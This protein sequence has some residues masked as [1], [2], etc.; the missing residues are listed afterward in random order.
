MVFPL[1]MYTTSTLQLSRAM[2]F[3]FLRIVPQ[4]F[5]W[6]ALAAWGATMAGLLLHIYRSVRNTRTQA[7]HVA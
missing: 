3:E 4:I 2:G 6:V 7:L 1:G 5:I